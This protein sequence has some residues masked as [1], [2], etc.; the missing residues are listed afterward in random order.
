MNLNY[1]VEF[2]CETVVGDD[3]IFISLGVLDF[4]ILEK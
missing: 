1:S 3:F 2:V 4:E